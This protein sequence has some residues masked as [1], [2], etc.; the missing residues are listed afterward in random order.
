MPLAEAITGASLYSLD[1]SSHSLKL[2]PEDSVRELLLHTRKYLP[3]AHFL[4]EQPSTDKFV[5]LTFKEIEK[6]IRTW[7]PTSAKR[8]RVWWA[9]ERE[10]SRHV[11]SNAWMSIGWKVDRV[12]MEKEIVTFARGREKK[13]ADNQL[14]KIIIP[15]RK[16][17]LKGEL[18]DFETKLRQQGGGESTIDTHVSRV[19]VFLNYCEKHELD[20]FEGEAAKKFISFK[21]DTVKP[22]TL[23]AY[24]QS[25]KTFIRA[26][27]PN[28]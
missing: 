26:M 16:K 3:L 9:N 19:S 1:T 15:M 2:V 5:D 21:R 22:S 23:I 7:L 6:L 11:Q 20:P 8:Y 18:G 27:A 4:L 24:R 14:D 10:S 12:Q 13:E 28:R 17:P 25:V